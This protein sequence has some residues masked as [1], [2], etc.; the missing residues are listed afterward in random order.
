MGQAGARSHVHEGGRESDEKMM[1]KSVVTVR[2]LTGIRAVKPITEDD[3]PRLRDQWFQEYKDILSGI[4]P[5]L[6]PLWEV[7]H[8]ITLIDEGKQYSYNLP[9][10]PDTLKQQLSDKIRLYT[11]AGW[12]EMKSVPQAAPMLC[13]PKKTGKLR[14]VIDCRKRND[15]T[16]KDVTPFPDQDQIWMD[17]ARAKYRS[18]IDLSNAYKQVRVEP[19]DVWKTAFSTI[20]G[21][22]ISQVMQ[23]GDCNAPATFQHLMMVIFCDHLGD[24]IY[25]YLNDLFVYSETIKEHEQHLKAVFEILR[26]NRFYLEKEKCDLYAVRLDCLRHIIDEKGVHANRD[27]MSRIRS[28]RTPRNLNEVQRFVGLVEYL[29]QFM[30]D[31]STYATPL[32]RIQRNGHPFQWR[33]IHDKCFQTIKALV[34]K[35]PILRPIDPSKPE[36]IWLMCDTLLYGVGALY[37]QGPKWKTCRPAG[38]MSKKLT[39]TQQNY[40][41]FK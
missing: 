11:D 3:I 31:V 10:C 19:Q 20:Y 9:R 6:P 15:N 37:G 29:V 13:I 12:W 4:I 39:D 28:W 7:N 8:R 33:E 22:F 35:Y 23:Q 40:W 25:T 5:T 34:C 26:K 16:V 30:P 41:T 17:V 1:R 36:P 38:F 2:R 21:T 18:K 27:K 32:T 24:F 14:M